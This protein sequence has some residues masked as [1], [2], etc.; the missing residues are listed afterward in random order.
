MATQEVEEL[1]V[2]L[3]MNIDL[4]TMENGVKLVGMALVNRNLNRWGVRNILR[5]A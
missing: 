4:S 1:V 5:S 3:E 2:N